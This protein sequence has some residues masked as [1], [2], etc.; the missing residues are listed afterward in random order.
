MAPDRPGSI[1]NPSWN[2][3][4]SRFPSFDWAIGS[5]QTVGGSREPG[6]WGSHRLGPL[7]FD[8]RSVAHGSAEQ[9]NQRL[10][11]AVP[12]EPIQRVTP[13]KIVCV[14]NAFARQLVIQELEL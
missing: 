14:L 11:S 6:G 3:G 13:D 9:L 7:H 5:C 1:P 10:V 4:G 2:H 8:I 12:H